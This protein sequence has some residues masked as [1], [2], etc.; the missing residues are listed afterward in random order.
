MKLLKLV[1]VVFLQ[2][3][4]RVSAKSPPIIIIGA[5]SAGIAA[6]ARLFENNYTNVKI[7]E[8]ENRIGG[9]IRSVFF[10][11]AFVDLGAESCHGTKDNVVYD[12]VKDF[13]ILRHSD[14]SNAVYY[15]SKKTI[16]REFGEEIISLIDSVYGPDGHRN[17]VEGRSLGWYCMKK[18]NSTIYD[19]YQKNPDKLEVAKS[20]MDL[21]RHI[22]L[23]Y[24]GAFSWFDPSAKSDYTDCEGDKQL[25]WN[26]M[27]YETILDI[28]MKKIPDPAKQLP[29]NQAVL[30]N[31]EVTKV[32]WNKN[33]SQNG[34]TV[35]CSDRTNYTADHV[36]LTTS[37][38]V[39]KE[40]QR[41]MFIPSLPRVKREAIRHIGFGA[42][43]KIALRFKTKWWED[44]FSGFLLIWNESDKLRV[45]EEFPQGPIKR[46]RSWLTEL[47]S[48]YPVAH[49]PNVLIAWLTGEV[50]P[51]VERMEEETMIP[52]IE[53]LLKK[54]MGH[55][56]NISKLD[57]I[58]KTSWYSNPHFRGSYS[59]QTPKA[60]RSQV[61]A[62]M[63]LAQ[64]VLNKNGKPILQF[65]GEATHAYFYSTVHGAIETGFREADRIINL[66]K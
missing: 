34:V 65:A 12:L 32:L 45:L 41:S 51:E 40:R 3:Y 57:A 11:E 38:G 52:G 44:N 35:V 5:G 37:I 7:L 47:Y 61:T 42:V 50:V 48:V 9:R 26:G 55:K 43:M 13:N 46:G 21:L 31:K 16:T 15:S 60:R 1:L 29:F 33:S 27:G 36:I 24:E 6:A 62:E 18:Y 49:N 58:I 30:L 17:V 14:A 63:E 59:Y 4:T 54:F 10:G 2:I 64:P 66:Y 19:K 56:Y 28:L 23:D 8:A 20:S 39:L 22:V 25:K 53:Y